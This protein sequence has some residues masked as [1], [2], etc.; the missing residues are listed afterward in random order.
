MTL[1]E[2]FDLAA[3]NPIYILAFF[4]LLPLGAVW[5]AW[6]GKDEGEE[7][8]WKFLYT[9]LIYLACI[10]GVFSITLSIYS[11]MFERRPILETNIY[12]QILPVISMFATLFIIQKNVNLGSIPGFGKVKGLMMML[13]GLFSIMWFLEKMHII[14]I[15]VIPVGG[16]ALLLIGIL[17]IIG[18]GFSKI[19]KPS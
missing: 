7:S 12:T 8:P 19:M 14:A 11:F 17:A 3:A 18:F 6:I 13:L 4:L 10:P 5:A 2:F 9:G 16:F 1:K 15:T